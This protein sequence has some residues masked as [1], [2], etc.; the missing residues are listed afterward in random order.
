LV[1]AFQ[2][3]TCDIKMYFLF[4]ET[5]QLIWNSWRAI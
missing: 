3:K 4:K 5:H 2:I 1:W